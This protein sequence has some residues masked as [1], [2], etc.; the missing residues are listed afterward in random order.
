MEKRLTIAIIGAGIAGLSL[1]S[2]LRDSGHQVVVFEREASA[3]PVGAGIVLWPNAVR[4]LVALGV[5]GQALAPH[6]LPDLPYGIRD[7][8]GRWLM[9]Q[10]L[11]QFG[12]T[13][14]R[15]LALH[16][17]VLID[18]LLERVPSESLR[19]HHHVVTA[20]HDGVVTWTHAGTSHTHRFDLIVGADGVRSRVRAAVSDADP[21]DSGITAWR[22]I[23]D[24]WPAVAGEVWGRG[25]CIGV[26]P[27]SGDQTYVYAAAR[28]PQ[29]MP[30]GEGWPADVRA[31]IDRAPADAPLTHDLWSLPALKTFTSGRVTLIG[32][33]AHAMLPFLGQGA[34]QGI[35]D[36]AALVACLGDLA[37]FDARRVA[38]ATGIQ[39]QSA[40]A[41]RVALASGRV[42]AL[43]DR[44][45]P[46]IPRRAAERRLAGL[47]NP[48]R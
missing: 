12:R 13:V 24:G 22:F 39:R 15:P 20:A 4:A 23:T 2:G 33:A 10:P 17:R 43:R 41:A 5:P 7:R 48:T 21:I 18:L 45:V 28:R 35:E 31:V 8:Q 36:A 26:V 9:Q 16:R 3:R 19:F 47:V 1:A 27:L 30:S 32:D 14:G 34:C 6:E 37:A 25:E 11:E 42:A 38:R 44:V 46:L 29:R 40:Q